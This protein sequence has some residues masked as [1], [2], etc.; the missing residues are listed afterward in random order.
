MLRPVYK[1][2][3]YPLRALSIIPRYTRVTRHPVDIGI[4]AE[5][6]VIQ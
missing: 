1:T 2:A 6:E 3:C 5:K 4:S